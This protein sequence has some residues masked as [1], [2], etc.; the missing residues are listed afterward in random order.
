MTNAYKYVKDHGI[1]LESEYPYEA[2]QH[3]CQK[4]S[5]DFKIKGHTTVKLCTT[6]ATD[7]TKGP[8]SVSVDASAW[9]NYDFGIF[10]DCKSH[11]NH[12][13]LLVGMTDDYWLV[14]NSWGR[15]WGEGG[16]IRLK[17]GNTCGVC[18][19]ASFPIK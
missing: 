12:G 13:V 5:G 18:S 6:L 7:L 10:S 4:D 14:K 16:Y 11:L 8:I 19:E 17:R 15:N 2:Q 3:T 9:S 1:A